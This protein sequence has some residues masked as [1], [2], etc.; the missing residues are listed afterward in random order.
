MQT[1]HLLWELTV[2]YGAQGSG[3]L[4]G[5]GTGFEYIYVGLRSSSQMEI[6]QMVPAAHMGGGFSPLEKE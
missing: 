6:G 3:C 1:D 2:S 4:L 5:I